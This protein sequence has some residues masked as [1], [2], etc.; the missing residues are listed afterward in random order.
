[1]GTSVKSK[2]SNHE[3]PICTEQAGIG[4]PGTPIF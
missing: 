2:S 3:T 4:T 1:M